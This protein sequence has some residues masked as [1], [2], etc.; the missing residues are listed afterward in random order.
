MDE[1][2]VVELAAPSPADDEASADSY[3]LVSDDAGTTSR[4][5]VDD[6]LFAAVDAARARASATTDYERTTN[7]AGDAVEAE[8]ADRPEE[9]AARPAARR[10]DL[11]LRP[12]DIQARIRAGESA[13]DIAEA[14]GVPLADIQRFEGPVLS[15]RAWMAQRARA[16]VPR[17][18]EGATTT[19]G[20]LAAERLAARGVSE[21]DQD[22]DSWR[23][24]DATWTVRL[25]WSEGNRTRL[26]CWRFDPVRQTVVAVD[27]SARD[28]TDPPA[29]RRLA[30]VEGDGD[31]EHTGRGGGQTRDRVY[32]LEADGGLHV[33]GGEGRRLRSVSSGDYSDVTSRPATDDKALPVTVQRTEISP[34]PSHESGEDEGHRGTTEVAGSATTDAPTGEASSDTPVAAAGHRESTDDASP[35]AAPA[36]STHQSKDEAPDEPTAATSSDGSRRKRRASVPSWDDILLGSRRSQ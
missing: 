34:S 22:W 17:R 31:Q 18:G 28:L 20:D 8:M 21:F 11:P 4:L 16:V 35:Q 2:H 10:P 30:A 1:L 26:A 36:G 27:D 23:R 19:M 24:E 29:P 5:R 7:D 25:T 15:E 14:A 13:Q 12:R 33:V 3:L 9:P 32:D 6:R